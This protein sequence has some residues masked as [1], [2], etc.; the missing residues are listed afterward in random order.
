[1]Y[2][3]TNKCENSNGHDKYIQRVITNVQMIN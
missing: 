1:M 2:H 3:N